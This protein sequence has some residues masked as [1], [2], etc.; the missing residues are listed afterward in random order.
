MATEP[1][2]IEAGE[3]LAAPRQLLDFPG[4]PYPARTTAV[5]TAGM[6]RFVLLVSG[7]FLVVMA[8]CGGGPETSSP[9]AP[10]ISSA[11]TPSAGGG[12]GALPAIDG[13]TASPGPD[14]GVV[15]ALGVSVAA[16][17]TFDSNYLIAGAG[18]NF[19]PMDNPT[20]V[21]ASQ[22]WWMNDDTIVMGLARSGESQAYPVGQMAYHHIANT[23]I[24]GEP[25]LV[26]Y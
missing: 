5:D 18:S 8:G 15:P 22:A 3:T 17:D 16:S 20:M 23:T 26:T 10:E 7:V 2:D 19:V 1:S 24:A 4:V 11:T 12:A 25:F 21:A 14:H 9:G 13:T 6:K